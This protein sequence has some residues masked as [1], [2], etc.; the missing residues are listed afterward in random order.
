MTETKCL[1]TFEIEGPGYIDGY[2]TPAEEWSAADLA[3]KWLALA[4]HDFGAINGDK[5]EQTSRR[6]RELTPLIART[7]AI[8][9]WVEGGHTVTVICIDPS[10]SKPERMGAMAVRRRVRQRQRELAYARNSS[11]PS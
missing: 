4:L 3:A 11:A 7:K 2:Y 5:K 1:W 10:V 8:E 6:A 9:T